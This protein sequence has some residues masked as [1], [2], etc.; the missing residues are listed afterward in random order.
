VQDGLITVA[1]RSGS[2]WNDG[3]PDTWRLLYFGT[4]SNALSAA[5]ADPDGDGASNWDEYVAGTNPLD[6]TSVFQFLPATAPAGGGFALQWPSVVNKH[7]TLQYSTSISSGN[8]TT[9]ATNLTG[10]G[11]PIQWSDPNV[12]AAARFYRALVQ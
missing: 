12:T 9:I 4:V 10:N 11:Q 1:N 6:A 8:W 2:S 7:Y 5:S 3:I